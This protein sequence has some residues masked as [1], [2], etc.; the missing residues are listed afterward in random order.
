MIVNKR[1]DGAVAVRLESHDWN[2]GA[3]T[4]LELMKERIPQT[5]RYYDGPN[6]AWVVNEL[7][8]P[9][10]VELTSKHF[11]YDIERLLA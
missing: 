1:P 9:A 5:A 11:G 7:Y 4:F 6:K 2:R 8:R 10:L 3:R